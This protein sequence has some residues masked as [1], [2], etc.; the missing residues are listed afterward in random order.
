ML[1]LL[2]YQVRWVVDWADHVWVET[3]F[4][5]EGKDNYAVD[6]SKNYEKSR[7]HEQGAVTGS[8]HRWI[9]C[10][11]CEAAVDEPLIYEVSTSQICIVMYLL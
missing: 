5:D 6:R 2:G 9:H 11:P 8:A 4:S 7:I 3:L 10:D 1:R